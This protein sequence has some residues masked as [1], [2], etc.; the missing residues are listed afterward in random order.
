MQD[1]T[2]AQEPVFLDVARTEDVPAGTC[3]PFSI[4]GEK[5]LVC[6]IDGAFLAVVNNCTHADAP[7]DYGKVEDGAIVCPMHNA[8]YDLRTGE[9][10]QS[11]L[12]PLRT[13]PVKIEA[14]RILV[15]V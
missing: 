13:Y 8:R 15:G 3:R 2:A 6:L 5:L 11:F 7:L 12:K 9:A 4:L 10:R 14:G 1:Q